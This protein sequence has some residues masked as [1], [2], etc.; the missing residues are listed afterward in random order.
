MTLP[1]GPAAKRGDR[2]EKLCAVAECL[3]MLRGDSEAIR[4]EDPKFEKV[5]IVVSLRSA[6]EL[7][8]I[9]RHHPSGKW[10]L[11]EL[12]RVGLL[13]AIGKLLEC[14]ES[15]FVLR[16]GS[17]AP[18]LRSLCEAARDAES[19]EEFERH[20]LEAD[21]RREAFHMLRRLWRCDSSTAMGRLQR[22]DVRKIGEHDL[23][24][25]VR[26]GV[27]ALFL[28]D[29]T[30]VEAR[31]RKIVEDSVHATIDREGLSRQ[32]EEYGH[33]PPQV[34]Q[35]PRRVRRRG[36]SY[37]PLSDGPTKQVDPAKTDR[38]GCD[39]GCSLTA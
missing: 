29:P 24:E 13:V 38:K 35:S 22:I 32:L 23:E 37:R 33:G 9:K 1:G 27:Q 34:A 20:F 30:A 17:D 4:I 11:A 19:S 6:R 2:Y 21:Q 18:E 39:A 28:T 10:S 3:R 12:K 26:W 31:L 25:M 36:I 8:R 16:S 14:G 15:R 5:D 7:H